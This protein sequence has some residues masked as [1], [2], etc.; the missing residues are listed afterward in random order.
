MNITE[1]KTKVQSLE[2]LSKFYD[3][4]EFKGFYQIN[5]NQE[6]KSLKRNV[7]HKRGHYQHI[8]EKIKT[9][10]I[11]QGYYRFNLHKN[12]KQFVI[13]RSLLMAMTFLGHKPDGYRIIVDHI[14]NNPL[15]DRLINLQLITAREN[16]SKDK[17]GFSS[18][19]T[20]VSWD[21]TR[22]KWHSQIRINGEKKYLGRFN[23][24]QDA[25]DA[26]QTELS[27]I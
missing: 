23:N 5:L 7:W 6:V 11:I 4:P 17:N 3:I 26:Y 20:G 13:K 25:S 21:K 10:T 8:K 15:D 22:N 14:N 24:E 2:D 27:K 9:P 18:K 16:T 1:F 12:G 19:Y